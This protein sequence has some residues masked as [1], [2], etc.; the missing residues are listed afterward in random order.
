[1]KKLYLFVFVVFQLSNSA[2]A[3]QPNQEEQ[4]IRLSK[5]KFEW[6]VAKNID[7]LKTVLDD[8]TRYVHS[9]GWIQTKQE[10]L[11]DVVSGKLD[12]RDVIVTEASVRLYPSVAILVGKGQFSGIV[13]KNPFTMSL[14]YTEVYVKKGAK[15]QLASRHANKM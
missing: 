9:N 8:Q 11:D 12:Y 14:L 7:S 3:Q 1:M 10:V 4:I 2:F 5:R 13:N 15:W 6:L